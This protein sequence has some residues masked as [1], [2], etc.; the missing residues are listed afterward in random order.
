[1]RAGPAPMSIAVTSRRPS[2]CS[3]SMTA[4]GPPSDGTP[5]FTMAGNSAASS[6]A[7]WLRSAKARSHVTA[8]AHQPSPTA[9]PAVA[10]AAARSRT[11]SPFRITRCSSRNTFVGVI[12]RIASALDGPLELHHRAVDEAFTDEELAYI[13]L[14]QIDERRDLADGPQ[15]ASAVDEPIHQGVRDTAPTVGGMHADE[16]DPRRRAG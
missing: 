1:M 10:R 12:A 6:L 11:S 5:A 16:I 8:A 9:P 4:M 3:S 2:T 15:L 14:G 13:G 7:W